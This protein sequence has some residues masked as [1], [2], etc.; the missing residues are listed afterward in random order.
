LKT[1]NAGDLALILSRDHKRFLQR[2]QPGEKL[3][4]HQGV[5]LHDDLINLPWGTQVRSHLG[6][7]FTIMEPSLRDLLLEIKRSSQIVYPKDIGYILLRLNVGPGKTILEAGTGSGAL[8]T[9]LAWTV[10]PTGKV[11]SYDR[12]EDMQ[13]LARR[14]LERVGLADRVDFRLKDIGEGFDDDPIDSLFLDLPDAHHYIEQVC[15]VLSPGSNMGAI[16]PTTNQVSA[17]LQVMGSAGFTE[18]DV[19][20]VLLRFYKT[21]PARIRPM[22]RMVAHTGYLLFARPMIDLPLE[23]D[24]ELT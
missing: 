5:I 6:T 10:G 14:N 13:S 9:A 2:I 20:E 24:E 4:S 18:M 8:T 3:E 21:V 23:D 1:I 22:D 12:R 15:E 17:M 11:I 16:L 7:R 19:C